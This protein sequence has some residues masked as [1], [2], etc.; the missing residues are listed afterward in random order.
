[1]CARRDPGRL[2]RVDAQ[3]PLARARRAALEPRVVTEPSATSEL[4]VP[5][6]LDALPAVLP[7]EGVLVTRLA[8]IAARSVS[9]PRLDVAGVR[10]AADALVIAAV[11]RAPLGPVVAITEDVDRARDLARDVRFL[12]GRGAGGG[13]E[14][15]VLASS[16]SSPY[17]DV[18]PD[19]RAA[20]SRMATLAHL[21]SGRPF[22][23]LV[24]AATG[25]ARKLVPPDVVREHTHRIVHEAELD[26]DALVRAL[27]ESGYIRVPVVED[28]GSFA[29]RGAL[30]DVWPPGADEPSRVELY[31]DLVLSIKPFDAAAQT[32]R[33]DATSKEIWLPPARDAILA[34]PFVER[35]RSRVLQ[36]ADMI[37]WP[38]TK[39]RMLVDDVATG[40]AFFGADAYLPAY[41]E[42]LAPLFAYLPRE[43]RVVLT[44]PSTLTRTIEEELERA[45]ADA[46]TKSDDPH[47]LPS[48]FLRSEEEIAGDLAA[49]RVTVLHGAAVAG[50]AEGLAAYEVTRDALHVAASDHD[51]LTRAVKSA[52]ASKGKSATLAPVARRIAHFRDGGLK[53]FLTARAQTQAERLAGLLRHQGIT[54]QIRGA[55]FDPSWLA[56]RARTEADA[57]IIVGP[58]GRGVILPGEGYVIVTEEEIFG[59]RAHRARERKSRSDKARPFVE[60][61]RSLHVGDYV[62]HAEHGIGRYMGLVHRDVGG[63]T[64]DLLVVEYAS[65]DKLYLPVYRLNQ[66][67]KY[68]GGEAGEPK[69]DRLGGA[70]FAKTKARVER[71]VRQMADELLRLYAERQ[72]QP[73]FALASA[74][75]EY[76]AFEAT[77]PFDETED[78]ARAID[79]VNKDLETPRPMDRLVCGDVGFGKTEIAIR[80]AFRVAM[81]G[82]QVAVLCPTTVLAQ[83]HFRTFE[84]RMHDYPISI[85]ALS[86]FQGKKEQ[87]ETLAAVKEGKVEIVIGTH[88]LLSKDIHFK[89]LGLLVVDEEQ[90]FGV[91]HKER[92]KQLRTQVDV[93]TLSA[94]PIP[95]TLQMAVSGL[96]DLSLITTPPMDR[97][98][99][100]TFVTAFD[101][102]VLKEAIGRELSRGG[103]VFYVYNRIEG[104]YE[105]AQRVQQLFPDARVAV[106]HGQM[107]GRGAPRTRGDEAGE[108]ALEK[109]M[110]D[111][112]EGRYDVL[113][114]TAIVESGLDIP[115]A[116]T[117]VIDRADLFGLAQLYQL[118]GRVGRSKERAYC[119]LIVPPPN[120]MT[121]EARARIEALERHTELGS[122]FKIASLDLELRGAGDL[123]GAEQS[124]NV[125]SVGLDMF[126]SMLDDA[127]H[128]L[129]GEPVVHDVDPELSFDVTALLPDDYVSDVGVR[130]SLYKRLASAIDEAHVGEIAVEMEDRFGAPPPEARG[131]VRL[132]TLK[133]ELR[134]LRVLGCEATAKSVTLHLREDTPLDPR[135]VL[136]LVKLPRS[137]YKLT[138]DRLTR[139]FDGAAD[140]LANCETML[141]ELSRCWRDA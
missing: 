102:Q 71:A 124:G 127:V 110:L 105:K 8:E 20:M 27:T 94:T 49:R 139:R 111:F 65:G 93:L 109:T 82:K 15:L 1:M 79:D 7:P 14:V 73:G 21:A 97:R 24:V 9:E 89:S 66:I 72:A 136:E 122:G 60:D 117:I 4:R 75:D 37:D 101:D 6:E 121:D 140:G 10:G 70:T 118:R 13:E 64:V 134:K 108:T 63:L 59:G 99:V 35:A 40:R 131:L 53:V 133:C 36:L 116:N 51:D 55:A 98:A 78:Q 138:P 22:R 90:R 61:L 26:R 25:L 129:R 115:R 33:G 29:V 23:V 2:S 57:E 130:L 58:L 96:R 119:Y 85:R 28:P 62:V 84:S 104:I 5:A 74:D 48:T 46:A 123:L 100:R 114:A 83:Q 34:K 76:R 50:E 69:V 87:D 106:A 19:R 67:Q 32:T 80:A 128:E 38:T 3:A 43:T 45:A 103:Q 81:S 12:L 92:I 11:A 41:Y 125:A 39:T 86:R 137:L 52:R 141:I 112:V 132:M 42:E 17:A 44:S 18:N 47:F 54:C 113:V 31:G 95:R 126:C 88:R 120:K 77:F 68:S 16:E 56:E 135:K 91:T 30:L 107:A